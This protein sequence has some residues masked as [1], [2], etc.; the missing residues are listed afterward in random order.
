[1]RMRIRIWIPNTAEMERAGAGECDEINHPP[2]TVRYVT[3]FFAFNVGT[4]GYFREGNSVIP[5]IGHETI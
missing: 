5:P 3:V 1:M 2:M 4:F